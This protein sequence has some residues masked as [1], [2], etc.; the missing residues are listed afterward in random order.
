MS[1]CHD[2]VWLTF[3]ISCM[4]ACF[5][6]FLVWQWERLTW[7]L[8]QVLVRLQQNSL[9]GCLWVALHCLKFTQIYTGWQGIQKVLFVRVCTSCVSITFHNTF[10]NDWQRCQNIKK[11]CESI[12]LKMFT[13]FQIPFWLFFI[14]FL[15]H[16][17]Q[18]DCF[19]DSV[20]SLIVYWFGGSKWK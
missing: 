4:S 8:Q 17:W 18:Q 14:T 20:K 7:K 1:F 19:I 9:S 11:I 2:V 15:I 10:L 5:H 13:F 12:C 6:L 16:M 3:C